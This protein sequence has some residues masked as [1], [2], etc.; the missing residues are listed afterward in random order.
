MCLAIAANGK[1]FVFGGTIEKRH[2]RTDAKLIKQLLKFT[3]NV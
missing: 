2:A 1:V 3:T